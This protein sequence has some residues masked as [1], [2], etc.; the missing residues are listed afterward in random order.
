[1]NAS[2][3]RGDR[4]EHLTTEATGYRSL[5]P[6]HVLRRPPLLVV[7]HVSRVLHVDAGPRSRAVALEGRAFLIDI[8]LEVS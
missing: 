3:T 7:E 6:A 1:M 8:S 2:V 4:G 5:A